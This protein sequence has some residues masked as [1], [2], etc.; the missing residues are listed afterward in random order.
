M[1]GDDVDGDDDDDGG[2]AV[3]HAGVHH[4]GK[5][6]KEATTPASRRG[7]DPFQNWVESQSPL[8]Q[9]GDKSAQK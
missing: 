1:V 6:G 8:L 5:D 7:F 4:K 9:L 2:T 3:V